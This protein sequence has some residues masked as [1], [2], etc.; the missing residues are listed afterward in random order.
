MELESSSSH[1]III[2]HV[3]AEKPEL[4]IISKETFEKVSEMMAV[5]SSKKEAIC[6]APKNTKGNSLL[7]GMIFCG[8]CGL[9]L[10]VTTSGRS[11]GDCDGQTG[12][13]VE[14]LDKMVEAVIL[15]L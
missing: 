11:H 10:Y 5:R 1:G 12:Y 14:K 4:A 3:W 15:S 6:S 8:H 7:A 9:R 13:T 2:V